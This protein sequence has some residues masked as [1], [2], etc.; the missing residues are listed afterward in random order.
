MLA[1]APPS[2]MSQFCRY[3]WDGEQTYQRNGLKPMN[4]HPEERHERDQMPDVER[5][6]GGI[7]THIGSDPLLVHE[8][9][10]VALGSATQS[11]CEVKRYIRRKSIYPA[12]AL[13]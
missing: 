1:V 12:T 13:T 7:N 8:R 6:C 11:A 10:Q 2:C 3:M 4:I 9:F 5:G